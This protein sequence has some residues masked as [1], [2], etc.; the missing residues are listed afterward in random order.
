MVQLQEVHDFVV[1]CIV[2]EGKVAHAVQPNLDKEWP[3]VWYQGAGSADAPPD[4]S[5][6]ILAGPEGP[7]FDAGTPERAA[8]V[9]L[10]D[11]AHALSFL[12]YLRW[13]VKQHEPVLQAA[14]K[15][16]ETIPVEVCP[17]DGSECETLRRMASELFHQR[18]GF[19]REWRV[20]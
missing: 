19:K 9:V 6:L 1:K 5:T 16:G 4:F 12:D 8:F 13:V 10:N 15:D 3:A 2:H 17:I 7:D 14:E 20:Q 11:P 18:P